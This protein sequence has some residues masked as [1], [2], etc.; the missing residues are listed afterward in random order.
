MIYYKSQIQQGCISPYANKKVVYNRE[1]KELEF[2]V[3]D[4]DS[5][6]IK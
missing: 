2:V 3:D 1:T 5:K 6:Y 4:T